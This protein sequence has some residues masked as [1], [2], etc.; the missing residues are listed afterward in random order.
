VL[1]CTNGAISSSRSTWRLMANVRGGACR[2]RGDAIGAESVAAFR[3]E[4]PPGAGSRDV[5]LS[6]EDVRCQTVGREGCAVGPRGEVDAGYPLAGGDVG[7][8]A[9]R[10]GDGD[11]DVLLELG[12]PGGVVGDVVL[13]AAPDDPTPGTTEGA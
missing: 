5:C 2:Q 12:V 11:G 3:P 7:P 9:R 6:G 13:P 4:E 1:V 8:W 10:A